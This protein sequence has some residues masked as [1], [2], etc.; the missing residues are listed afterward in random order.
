M[1]PHNGVN[2]GKEQCRRRAQGV[3]RWRACSTASAPSDTSSSEAKGTPSLLLRTPHSAGDT[4]QPVPF[5]CSA[6]VSA[7][8]RA[9]IARAKPA[10]AAER[11]H[12]RC[13]VQYS[14]VSHSLLAARHSCATCCHRCKDVAARVLANDILSILLILSYWRTRCALS[15]ARR[16]HSASTRAASTWN[17]SHSEHSTFE[18]MLHTAV[19]SAGVTSGSGLVVLLVLSSGLV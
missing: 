14:R 11:A 3:V 5:E 7:A 16:P 9:P 6:C 18:D 8:V 1:S 2:C 13:N 17:G 19:A 4:T 10:E 15:V 12:C